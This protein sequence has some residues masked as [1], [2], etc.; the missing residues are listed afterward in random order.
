MSNMLLTKLEQ[1][2]KV[3]SK[4][5]FRRMCCQVVKTEIKMFIT[6]HPLIITARK[7]RNRLISLLEAARTMIGASSCMIRD[8]KLTAFD[9]EL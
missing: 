6:P 1:A 9:Y 7:F 2:G 8:Y 3:P 4:E 5:K